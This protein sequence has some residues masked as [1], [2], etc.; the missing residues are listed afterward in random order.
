MSFHCIL[1]LWK[2]VISGFPAPLKASLDIR[3]SW[4][5]INLCVWLWEC[6]KLYQTININVAVII[7]P[8]R[9]PSW[10]HA[11]LN[12]SHIFRQCVRAHGSVLNDNIDTFVSFVQHVAA[13]RRKKSLFR[14]K[15]SGTETRSTF[16]IFCVN[17]YPLWDRRFKSTYC[18]WHVI[19]VVCAFLLKYK[20]VTRFLW[21]KY[22]II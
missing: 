18:N 1:F 22:N 10:K 2:P 5:G 17:Q 14:R 12:S 21:V 15:W 9:V 7:L 16:L 3:A 13:R 8:P 4:D 20:P 11:F 19:A 6:V